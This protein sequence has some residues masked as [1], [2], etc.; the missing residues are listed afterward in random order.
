MRDCCHL[1][2]GC[3]KI[4][5]FQLL[6]YYDAYEIENAQVPSLV[7]P[8]RRTCWFVKD[9]AFQNY[10]TYASVQSLRKSCEAGDM[11]SEAEI[12]ALQVVQ[13]SN[14]SNVARPSRLW[15]RFHNV[16]K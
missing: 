16:K 3:R 2:I 7:A 14:M 4:W 11:L 13:E 12:V 6:N 9:K 5:R 15:R 8:L 1:Y 10:D